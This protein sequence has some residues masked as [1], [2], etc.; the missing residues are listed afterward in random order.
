MG[1]RRAAKQPPGTIS[2]VMVSWAVASCVR[3]C[4]ASAAIG[5]GAVGPRRQAVR[6]SFL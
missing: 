5:V 4:Q 1:G 6:P 3:V 2:I